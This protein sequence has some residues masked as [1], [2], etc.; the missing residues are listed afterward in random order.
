MPNDEGV[1]LAARSAGDG[2]RMHPKSRD[3]MSGNIILG[4][5]RTINKKL[6]IYQCHQLLATIAG[7]ACLLVPGISPEQGPLS[8]PALSLRGVTEVVE[9]AIQRIVTSSLH[10]VKRLLL[11]DS[12]QTRARN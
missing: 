7:R 12:I 9:Y 11:R 6:R 5:P 2:G 4:V 3:T 8:K 10:G 1:W